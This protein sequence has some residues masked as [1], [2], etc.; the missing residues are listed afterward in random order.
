MC[1]WIVT[2]KV[3]GNWVV[4]VTLKIKEKVKRETQGKATTRTTTITTRQLL[5]LLLL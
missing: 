4:S 5:L 1:D 3:R 2:V